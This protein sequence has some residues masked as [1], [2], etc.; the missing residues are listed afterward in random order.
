MRMFLINMM[1]KRK[2]TTFRLDE[3]IIDV[4]D[5]VA[6]RANNSRNKYL[7][8][9]LMEHFKNL[10]DLPEDFQPLGETRGGDRSKG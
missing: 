9:L 8:I 6:T 3:R 1:T 2:A 7:E 10:G 4:L 5:K